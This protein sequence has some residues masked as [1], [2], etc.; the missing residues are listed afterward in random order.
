MEPQRRAVTGWEPRVRCCLS[1]PGQRTHTFLPRS[2]A[3]DPCPARRATLTDPCA[4]L[5]ADRPGSPDCGAIDDDLPAPRRRSPTSP[6]DP[7]AGPMGLRRPRPSV[8]LDQG[9][10]TADC[11]RRC[12]DRPH[13]AAPWLRHSGGDCRYALG[14]RKLGAVQRSTTFF[15]SITSCLRAASRRAKLGS[16][17]R[18]VLV[19]R[20]RLR[21]VELGVGRGR[22]ACFCTWQGRAGATVGQWLLS[23]WLLSGSGSCRGGYC[24]AAPAEVM[25]PRDMAA[26][27][28]A[29]RHRPGRDRSS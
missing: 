2:A 16:G 5:V 10:T 24:R 6:D 22:T 7:P 27:R 9:H 3:P 14:R 28:R 13:R 21:Q 17:R 23:G 12:G 15:L 19:V 18:R 8:V 29:S 11:G 26:A 1:P 4:R 25:R 20:S